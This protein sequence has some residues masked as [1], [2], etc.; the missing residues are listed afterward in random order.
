MHGAC[1]MSIWDHLFDSNYRQRN[2][3]N[4]QAAEIQTIRKS[5]D[6]KCHQLSVR[7]DQL[8]KE[9]AETRLI[10]DALLQTLIRHDLITEEGFAELAEQVKEKAIEQAASQRPRGIVSIRYE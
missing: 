2:D 7:I 5:I 6:R 4:W 3:I 8:E 10:C 1:D 9:N